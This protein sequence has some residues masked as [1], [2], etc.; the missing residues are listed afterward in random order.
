MFN[1][2][3]NILTLEEI[4]VLLALSGC[5]AQVA[6]ASSNR[7]VQK[8]TSCDCVNFRCE[9]VHVRADHVRRL[10]NHAISW[11]S[12]CEDQSPPGT[13]PSNLVN[14]SQA[15]EYKRWLTMRLQPPP[16]SGS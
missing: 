15:A 11:Y 14:L 9:I 2:L 3:N 13:Q 6:L 5:V 10:T 16:L 12:A 4:L 7:R 8:L 1:L